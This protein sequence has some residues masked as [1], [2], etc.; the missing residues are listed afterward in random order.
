MIINNDVNMRAKNA[1]EITEMLKELQSIVDLYNPTREYLLSVSGLS[2]LII[3]AVVISTVGAFWG[4]ILIAA[5]VIPTILYVIDGFSIKER[6]PSEKELSEKACQL[7]SG[8]IS[9]YKH[10]EREY[11]ELHYNSYFGGNNLSL[12]KEFI[13]IFPQMASKKLKKLSSIHLRG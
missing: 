9:R 7:M 8:C 4:V 3:A 2:M 13:G 5:A 1:Q 6:Y 12:Y 11:H 10:P